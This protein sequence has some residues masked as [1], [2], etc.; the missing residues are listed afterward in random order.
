MQCFLTETD[1]LGSA[2][3]ET[4]VEGVY[5]LGCCLVKDRQTTTSPASGL[6]TYFAEVKLEAMKSHSFRYSLLLFSW[7][8]WLERSEA[9]S[10]TCLMEPRKQKV[11]KELANHL[12]RMRELADQL[13]LSS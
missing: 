2:V 7:R 8:L 3:E 5:G 13:M 6:L 4:W 9:M 10:G 1:I 11:K 12:C